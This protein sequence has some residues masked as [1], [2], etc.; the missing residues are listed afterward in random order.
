MDDG[1]LNCGRY[2]AAGRRYLFTASLS[3]NCLWPISACHEGAVLGSIGS[4]HLSIFLW[5]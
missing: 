4:V 3:T 5:P 2:S 1:K